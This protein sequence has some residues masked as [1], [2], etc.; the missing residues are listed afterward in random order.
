M[1]CTCIYYYRFPG[2][3]RKYAGENRVPV[4]EAT[5]STSLQ[6]KENGNDAIFD[7]ERE[8]GPFVLMAVDS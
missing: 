2:I 8:C 4:W 3:T 6:A 1:A 5:R 7:A